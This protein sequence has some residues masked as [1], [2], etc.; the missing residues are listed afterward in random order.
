MENEV[1]QLIMICTLGVLIMPI[2][3]ARAGPT[4]L[5][6]ESGDLTG[7]AGFVPAGASTNVVPGYADTTGLGS[8]ATT[9]TALASYTLAFDYFWD[10]Q[11]YVPFEDM[12]TGTL[13]MGAG[14]DGPVVSTLFSYSVSTDA[15]DYRGTLW[16]SVSHQFTTAGTYTQSIEVVNGGDSVL[17]N[18]V[19]TNNA[20][21][22]PAPGAILLGSSGV[23]VAGWL[24]RQRL[25]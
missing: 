6:S 22:I 19:G 7:W 14:T 8:G 25:L 20:R 1:K 11:D 17:D 21:V 13:L 16:T 23:G 18:Y 10:S 15:A 2:S 3:G 5:S 12:T 9:W 4:N 24:R